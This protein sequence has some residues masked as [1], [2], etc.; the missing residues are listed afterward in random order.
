M[1]AKLIQFILGSCRRREGDRLVYYRKKADAAYWDQLWKNCL[2]AEQYN[3]A[4]EG[5]LAYLEEPFIRY[6]PKDGKILEAG[7]GVGEVVLAVC[8]R[9]Y[10]CEGVDWGRETIEAV[11]KLKPD[12]PVRSGDVTALDVPDKYYSACIS[13][14]VVEHRK[15]GPEPFIKEAYRILND[16]GIL[17]LSVPYFHRIR[18]INS[19]MNIFAQSKKRLEFYQYAFSQVE[20]KQF[21]EN[22]GFIVTDVFN[23]GALKGLK[24][25]LVL[26]RILLR[27]PFIQSILKKIISQ[28]CWLTNHFG[29]MIMFVC[30]KKTGDYEN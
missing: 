7:C 26:V 20:M 11:H 13:L 8:T 5:K 3:D 2:T 22:E 9:G 19:F 10:D 25:E 4:A 14:G 1:K 29:H 23:Y 27:I 16:Q 24:D 6:L 21:L 28:S 18:R 15:E 17:L 30:H 12:L